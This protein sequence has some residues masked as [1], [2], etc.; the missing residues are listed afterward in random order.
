M[1]DLSYRLRGMERV[2]S[3]L[4]VLLLGRPRRSRMW[5]SG[6]LLVFATVQMQ[7]ATWRASYW[8]EQ[9]EMDLD[10]VLTAASA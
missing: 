8:V 10:G 9:I 1:R 7:P 6:Q 5:A 4:S 3:S 2:E